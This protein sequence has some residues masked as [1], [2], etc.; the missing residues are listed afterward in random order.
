[1]PSSSTDA[2]DSSLELYVI[3]SALVAHAPSSY[4]SPGLKSV[5]TPVTIY[6]TGAST[7]S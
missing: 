3:V 4:V 7:G 1:M 6:T 2:T 5:G